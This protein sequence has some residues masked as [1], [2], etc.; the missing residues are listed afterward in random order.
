MAYAARVMR[1]LIIDHVRNRKAHKRG[2]GF[3]ITSLRPTWP[4]PAAEAARAG[5]HRRGGGRAGPR[6]SRAGPGGGPQVLLRLLLRRDRGHA[7]PVGAHRAAAL[8]EGAPLPPRGDRRMRER[9]STERWRA[10][11]PHLDRALELEPDERQPPGSL[12]AR[13][14][15]RPGR[16]PGGAAPAEHE[17][18]DEG[19]L[20]R[21][22]GRAGRRALAGRPDRRRLHAALADRPGRHGQR[23]AG[24]AQRRPLPRARP[25][26][27]C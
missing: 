16:R 13:G 9:L 26:S 3:E 12:A 8:A 24:R 2:G 22:P 25:R 17:A 1:T 21:R 11:I 5:A 4:T 15:R 14:G 10:L 19:F 27:S 6:R 20:E 23:L 7:R 18:L